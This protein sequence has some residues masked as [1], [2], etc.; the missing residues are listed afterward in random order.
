MPSNLNRTM[1]RV[2]SE[3]WSDAAFKAQL[4]SEPKPAL[5]ALDIVLPDAMTITARENTEQTLHLAISAP[6]IA[7]PISA[8]SEIRDFAEVYRDPRLW[9]LNWIGRDPVA[10]GRLMADPVDELRKIGIR[11][12]KDLEIV[13]RANT[14]TLTHL[15]LPPQPPSPGNAH[16]TF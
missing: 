2:I 6:P 1:G 13:V 5:A 15:I 11:V 3:A 10:A 4:L 9:S 16:L 14:A 7:M 8:L 12:P